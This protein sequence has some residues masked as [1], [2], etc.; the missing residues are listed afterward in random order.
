MKKV[1]AALAVACVLLASGCAPAGKDFWGNPISTEE[2][3]CDIT[4]ELKAV[5]TAQPNGALLADPLHRIS[6]F[7][8]TLNALAIDET[9]KYCQPSVPFAGTWDVHLYGTA[10]GEGV[11]RSPDGGTLPWDGTVK[12]PWQS[13][14]FLR[15]PADNATPIVVMIDFSAKL[16]ETYADNALPQYGAGAG[17]AIQ[18][19]GTGAAGGNGFFADV[20]QHNKHKLK[21]GDFLHCRVEIPV[22]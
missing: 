4:P 21:G 10:N 17:C 22:I 3:G 8:I 20:A 2:P 15:I 16:R 11:F 6:D 14:L 19:G 1:L 5:P 18:Y 12:S 13:D 7:R 9:G